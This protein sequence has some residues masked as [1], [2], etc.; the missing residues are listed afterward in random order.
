MSKFIGYLS[1]IFR[2]SKKYKESVMFHLIKS[3]GCQRCGGD[4][5]LEQDEY[6]IYISCI[7]CGTVH[8]EYSYKELKGFSPQQ[9]VE[10]GRA[11]KPVPT[12][13]PAQR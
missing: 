2:D 3:K 1:V 10:M 7:Q 5:F 4:L 8:A 13:Q 12:A 6:G 9:V 11:G